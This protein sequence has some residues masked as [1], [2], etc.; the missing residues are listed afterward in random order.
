MSHVD[1]FNTCINT[2]LFS[3][4]WAWRMNQ[5]HCYC[6]TLTKA[7]NIL[8]SYMAFHSALTRHPEPLNSWLIWTATG[9]TS[10]FPNVLWVG[11]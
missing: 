4:H 1:H 8:Q 9:L 11:G 3:L 5:H 10:R 6:A 2:R 7:P